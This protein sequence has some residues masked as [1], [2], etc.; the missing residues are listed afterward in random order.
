MDIAI[1]SVMLTLAGKRKGELN[2]Y[3]QLQIE[4][5]GYQG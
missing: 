4:L 2:P 3:R 5:F 1:I